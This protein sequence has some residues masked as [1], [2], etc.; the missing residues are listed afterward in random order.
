M[1]HFMPLFILFWS[2]N[3]WAN[4]QLDSYLSSPEYRLTQWAAGNFSPDELKYANFRNSIRILVEYEIPGLIRESLQSSITNV[5]MK[6]GRASA[7]FG[8]NV[9]GPLKF[10]AS[11]IPDLQRKLGYEA[12]S[13]TRTLVDSLGH[14]FTV[15]ESNC[16]LNEPSLF[17]IQKTQLNILRGLVTL[18]AIMRSCGVSS[19]DRAKICNNPD[20]QNET[21]LAELP[22]VSSLF[23][24][25]ATHLKFSL[26]GY[27][28]DSSLRTALT[29]AQHTRDIGIEN[30]QESHRVL[31]TVSGRLR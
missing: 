17:A 27:V 16:S 3:T 10:A 15:I 5:C 18:S 28:D 19:E 24:G 26:E 20:R 12:E 25:T 8:M 13:D 2:L 7:Y 9:H 29:L 14:L 22:R 11:A 31:V 23:K 21:L 6:T 4:T 30:S 1:R